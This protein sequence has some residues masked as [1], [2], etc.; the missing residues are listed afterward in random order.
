MSPG[1]LESSAGRRVRKSGRQTLAALG[2][3]SPDDGPATTGRHAGP[4]AVPA[5][6]LQETW[7]KS[8]LHFRDPVRS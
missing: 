1:E 6:A 2:A 7:L 3:T 5:R 4:E 8:T